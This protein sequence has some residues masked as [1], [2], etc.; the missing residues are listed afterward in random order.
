M[1]IDEIA[2]QQQLLHLDKIPVQDLLVIMG[3]VLPS[4][5][6]FF[7]LTVPFDKQE[8]RSGK[9]HKAGCYILLQMDMELT[10]MDTECVKVQFMIPYKPLQMC[11]DQLAYH[12][13]NH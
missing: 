9:L 4:T 6:D 13:K 5:P 8:H 10:I 7:L 1:R 12:P 2:S 3:T 11:L